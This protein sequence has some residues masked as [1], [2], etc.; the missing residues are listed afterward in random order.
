MLDIRH[1]LR[2]VFSSWTSGLTGGASAPLAIIAPFLE[3]YVLRTVFNLFAV[4]CFL[5]AAFWVWRK[6]HKKVEAFENNLPNLE[7]TGY[8]V[9]LRP[10]VRGA[11]FLH[12]RITNNP[13]PLAGSEAEAKNV[14][15]RITFYEKDGQ[16]CFPYIEG[17]WSDTPQPFEVRGPNAKT[18]RPIGDFLAVNFTIGR[19]QELAIAFKHAG[20]KACY[21]FNHESYEYETWGFKHEGRE[22]Y[23][24]EFVVRVE[25]YGQR[26][27]KQWKLTFSNPADG[28]RAGTYEAI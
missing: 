12:L 6:E 22:L 24:Q 21:P 28:L 19:T 27:R 1:F 11:T 5:F 18:P 10:A 9:D 20:D 17:R 23:G 3:S 13:G 26:V 4:G 8:S 25:L 7:I 15:A 16:R 14:S 2:A